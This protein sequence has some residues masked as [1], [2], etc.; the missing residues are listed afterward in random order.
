[1]SAL[2]LEDGQ[3]AADLAT[4][5][6]RAKGVDESGDVRL[7]AL[8]SVLAAWTCVV[9]GGGL[10]GNGLVLGL[11]TYALA[12]PA[13][14]DVTV[15]LAAITD[16]LARDGADSEPGSVPTELPVPP[17][18]TSPSWAALSPP[19]G[20]WEPVGQVDAAD[21][22]EAARAGIA[23]IAQGAPSGSGAAAVADL[24]R[25]VWGRATGTVPPVPSGGAFGLHALGFLGR[26]DQERDPVTVHAAGPWTRLST[27]AG[28]VLTR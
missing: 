6:R 24:R 8:G 28:F 1:M 3:S 19:R 25:R 23:E 10:L 20:G 5:V 15:P 12:E 17:M 4:Y 9:P 18:T 22:E 27:R 14:L 13:H 7:Q 11:R 21:L 26:P 2:R 16:R